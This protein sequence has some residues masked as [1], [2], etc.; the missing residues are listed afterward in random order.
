MCKINKD[1]HYRVKRKVNRKVAEGDEWVTPEEIDDY[2]NEAQAYWVRSLVKVSEAD[3]FVDDCLSDLLERDKKLT[4]KEDPDG[5]FAEYP[6]DY[7]KR[8]KVRV[9]A[10]KPCDKVTPDCEECKGRELTVRIVSSDDYA[11]AVKSPYWRSSFEYEEILG[12]V[13]KG[14]L[15]LVV[16]DFKIDAV[17]LDYYRMPKEMRTPTLRKQGG[18][19]TPDGSAVTQDQCFELLSSFQVEYVT[20]IAVIMIE[21]DTRNVE[22]WQSQIQT[23]INNRQLT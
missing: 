17:Y 1:I 13:G 7:L 4:V 20:D 18:Y 8:L 10:S 9:V 5:V 12:K 16:R 3:Q 14:G 23:I 15:H 2:V 6:N 11:E 22:G 19:K 21:R